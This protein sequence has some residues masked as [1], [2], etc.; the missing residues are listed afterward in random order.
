MVNISVESDQFTLT[1]LVR[2]FQLFSCSTVLFCFK[3]IIPS[4][5]SNVFLFFGIIYYD[6]FKEKIE[7]I[8]LSV[9]IKNELELGFLKCVHNY[10]LTRFHNDLLRFN[11]FMII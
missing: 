4:I 5:V 11:R 3:Y 9:Q 10:D 6:E 8:Y 2:I 1:F 7:T